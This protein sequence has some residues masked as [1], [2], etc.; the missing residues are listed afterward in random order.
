MTLQSSST[1]R[2]GVDLRQA[3]NLSLPL[4]APAG[5]TCDALYVTADVTPHSAARLAEAL[6]TLVEPLPSDRQRL[7]ESGLRRL[8]EEFAHR[9]G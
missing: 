3:L 1:E 8:S 7:I 9:C 2:L 5:A 6:Q 4:S